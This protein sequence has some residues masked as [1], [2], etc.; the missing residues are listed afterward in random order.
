M[1]S[2]SEE[3]VLVLGPLNPD[4]PQFEVIPRRKWDSQCVALHNSDDVKIAEGLLRNIRSSAMEGF[5][6]PLD[7]LD[8]VVQVS[9]T[10]VLAEAPDEWRYS[11]VSWP[12]QRVFLNG[13]SLLHHS[14]RDTYNMWMLEQNR[15]VGGSNRRYSMSSR[16]AP[17][18]VAR[19]AQFLMVPPLLMP[20]LAI[21]VVARIVFSTILG[22]KSRFFGCICTIRQRSNSR[23]IS[24]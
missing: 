19:N 5:S 9:R 17:H 7:E 12:M 10:F 4:V 24:S 14:Q 6:G 21:L 23:V 8:V 18:S 11:F 1:S 3:G 15:P 20:L 16:S 13:T 2:S 22:R